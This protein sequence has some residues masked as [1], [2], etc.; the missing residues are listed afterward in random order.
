MGPFLLENRDE[1]EIEF[2]QKRAIGAAG[3]IVVGEL[4]NKVDDEVADT[5]RC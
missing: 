2:V 1:N 5:F 3:V 4:N